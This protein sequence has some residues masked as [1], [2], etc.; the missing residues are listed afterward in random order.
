VREVGN[1]KPAAI[2]AAKCERDLIR[3][4]RL[5]FDVI[6]GLSES[7]LANGARLVKDKS[8]NTAEL[9]IDG[10]IWKSTAEFASKLN[11][12]PLTSSEHNKKW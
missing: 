11:S 3:T 6:I 4:C 9:V 5:L 10:K 7:V 12:A 2:Q 1:G 8:P